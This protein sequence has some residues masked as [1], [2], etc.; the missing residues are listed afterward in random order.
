M[1]NWLG[2]AGGMA[3]GAA[4]LAAPAMAQD[5]PEGPK[6]ALG[7]KG[8]KF[9]TDGFELNITTRVQARLTYQNEVGNGETGTNGR[10]FV[11]FRIRRAKTKFSGYIFDKQFQYALQ[12]AWTNSSQ[13]L[14]E[15]AYFR[16]AWNPYLNV[17]VGQG[18]LPWNWEEHTS[19]GTQLFVERGYVNSAF[20]H[21][22]AKGLWIDGR[23]GED[24]PWVKY[25]VGV[26]NGVLKG[27]TDFRNSDIK[28]NS[29]SFSDGVVDGDM[30]FNLRLETHP[31]GEVKKMY[32]DRGEDK[33]SDVLFSVGLGVNW[34]ITGFNDALLRPDTG[35]APAPSSSRNRTSQDT[36]SVTLDGHFRWHGLS[37]DI[38]WYW[39]HTDLHNKGRNDFRPG[40]NKAGVADL[41]DMGFT[42]DIGYFILPK[43]LLVGVRYNMLNA[44]DF[45]DSTSTPTTQPDARKFGIRPD[46]TEM[47]LTVSYFVHGDNLRLTFDVLYVDQQLAFKGTTAS[48]LGVYNSPPVRG[49]FTD[50]DVFK[51]ADH[52]S[53][54]IVRLQLQWI[55]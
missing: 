46:T 15:D 24:T 30:M 22:F 7:N 52:N 28:M 13:E 20:N 47:G 38:A 55:F 10:D 33:Y 3:L 5:A 27:N 49:A 43:Q 25:W 44:D 53:L 14:I 37:A 29:E 18:K 16:W 40:Q 50:G 21:G 35:G 12:L 48:Q 51:S 32:D 1:S 54:W 2:V 17:G 4:L 23:V 6:T 8:L 39:R 26:Y 36:L 41:E 45:W 9:S 42:F 19:S 11:N 34:L 31:M